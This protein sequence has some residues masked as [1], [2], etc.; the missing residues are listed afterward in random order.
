MLLAAAAVLMLPI[1]DRLIV[2][3]FWWTPAV[4]VTSGAVMAVLALPRVQGEDR[5]PELTSLILL[6]EDT[7]SATSLEVAPAVEDSVGLADGPRVVG[8][9]RVPGTWLTVEGPGEDWARS[10]AVAGVVSERGPDGL[11]LPEGVAWVV[12]GTGPA[13]EVSPPRVEVLESTV[14]E[15]MWRLRVVVAPG[16]PGEMLG[17][18]L[19]DEVAGRIVAVDGLALSSPDASLPVRSVRRWGR[20]TD[21]HAT[22]QLQID[23]PPGPMFFDLVEHHLRPAE[24]LG[25]PFF[26]RDRT[27]IP[28]A[29]TGS[30]RLVQRTT[31]RVSRSEGSGGS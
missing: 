26:E 21:E 24:I 5:H 17:L 1:A 30:D 10:W 7:M 13:A 28:D 2:P 29:S 16:L 14:A 25:E 8:R 12:A 6:V 31:V 11:L 19:P 15:G 18:R 20:G 4:A 23:A 9:R 22:F 3:R 27:L